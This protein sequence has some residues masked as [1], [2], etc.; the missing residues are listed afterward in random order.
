MADFGITAYRADG[1]VALDGS[2]KAGVFVGL[3]VAPNGAAGSK[4]YNDV[5]TGALYY[6]V[7]SS[8]GKHVITVGSDGAGRAKIT[9]T[10]DSQSSLAV[11]GDTVLMVF[12]KRVTPASDFGAVI[13]ADNG[14]TL[15][16]YT[17]PVPQYLT[18]LASPTFYGAAVI[19]AAGMLRIFSFPVP[20]IRSNTNRLTL[21][22]L[23]DSS[24]NDIWYACDAFIPANSSQQYL[25]VYMVCANGLSAPYNVPTLHLF[26]IDGP[27]SG[28]SSYG[29]QCFGAGG[30]LV[31]DSS[32]ENISI[33]DY[34]S[35][36]PSGKNTAAVSYDLA[37]PSLAG[38]AAPF[39]EQR[40]FDKQD[41]TAERERYVGFVQRKGA[42]LSYQIKLVEG[43]VG[44]G[45]YP[46]FSSF[47][48][49]KGNV[50]G[51]GLMVADIS[52]LSPAL[53]PLS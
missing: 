20:A 6:L 11:S 53:I 52:Q 43:T 5:P 25:F 15:A 29:V 47:F 36:V 51:G 33:K 48:N 46:T 7:A 31:F 22:H 4:V 45:N 14:D 30:N 27:V 40:W 41:G 21:M 26:S 24:A 44:G 34:A 13:T 50:G 38:V 1:S 8:A 16:D 37:T 2:N 19:G 3:L 18:T 35:V 17:Y 23:P 32:A 12:A 39:F 9:W 10:L 28:G 49:Q 42:T